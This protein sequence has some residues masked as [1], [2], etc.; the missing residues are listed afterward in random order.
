MNLTN[1]Y[2]LKIAQRLKLSTD[3]CQQIMRLVRKIE[4]RTWLPFPHFDI[5]C[6]SQWIFEPNRPFSSA[7][8][9]R[10]YWSWEKSRWPCFVICRAD[11]RAFRWR[12]KSTKC[13]RMNLW[14]LF[15]VDFRRLVKLSTTHSREHPTWVPKRGILQVRSK[16]TNCFYSFLRGPLRSNWRSIRGESIIT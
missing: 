4:R 3:V 1:Y 10:I 8:F 5:F 12:G 14:H 13:G 9:C 16:L 15:G 2:I 7:A 6:R 11:F